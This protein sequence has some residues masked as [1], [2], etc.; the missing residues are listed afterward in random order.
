MFHAPPHTHTYKYGWTSF[1]QFHSIL[2]TSTKRNGIQLTY[3]HTFIW[4]TRTLEAE[5]KIKVNQTWNCKSIF[6][7]VSQNREFRDSKIPWIEWSPSLIPFLACQEF[8]KFQFFKTNSK[9]LVR[10][11]IFCFPESIKKTLFWLEVCMCL[12]ER[13]N[14]QTKWQDLAYELDFFSFR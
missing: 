1:E 6:Y 8:R 13:T 11:A 12:I 5:C 2:T 10:L 3:V 14:N 7:F 4:H 9:Y